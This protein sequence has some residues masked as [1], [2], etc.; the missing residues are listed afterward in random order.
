MMLSTGKLPP[1]PRILTIRETSR[2]KK[3]CKILRFRILFGYG[4]MLKQNFNR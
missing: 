2:I 3:F 4:T 1:S